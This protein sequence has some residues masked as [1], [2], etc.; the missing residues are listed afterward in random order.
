M[1]LHRHVG[2]RSTNMSPYPILSQMR[3]PFGDRN[4]GAAKFRLTAQCHPQQMR[5]EIEYAGFANFR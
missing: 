1:A 2:Q 3:R 4:K 5:K